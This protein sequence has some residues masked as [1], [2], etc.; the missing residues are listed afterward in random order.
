MGAEVRVLGP[1]PPTQFS[2]ADTAYVGGADNSSATLNARMTADVAALGTATDV[3][4]V[5]PVVVLGNVYLIA[6]IKA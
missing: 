2:K 6:Y 3:I 4:S 5:E 1:Y